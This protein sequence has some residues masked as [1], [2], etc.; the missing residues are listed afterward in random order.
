M[1]EEHVYGNAPG[2]PALMDSSPREAAA[3]ALG[4]RACRY[5]IAIRF[6]ADAPVLSLLL[7]V[8]KHGRH[9]HPVIVGMNFLGNH[10][11]SPD[12][13]I[14]LPRIAFVPGMDVAPPEGRVTEAQ[15]GMQSDR[16]PIERMLE[17]GY[18]VATFYYGDV[19]PDRRDGRALS[20]QPLF[21]ESF[22][23]G[24]IAT[25]SWGMSRALDALKTMPEIEAG[26]M[27]LVGHSRQG[28]AALWAAA[29]D[30][31]V[32]LVIANNSGKGG[33]S[34]ARRNFGETVRHLV[35][36][37]PHWFAGRY[38][39]YAGNEAALPVDQH[40]LI[41]LVAPR[42]VYVASAADDGWADPKGE[43]LGLA[44]ANPV[45]RLLGTEGLPAEEQPRVGAPIASTNGY[46]IRA[47][48]HGVT[49]YDW[50]RFLDFCDL[51]RG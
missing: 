42:P 11:V 21:P 22:G 51:H 4:G 30:P 38:A 31:R 47:G 48:G 9:P 23:W 39:G 17:R 35:T 28:K 1:F 15:R 2:A 13:G 27:A 33:A 12:P 50:E 20:V 44:G 43:F 32:W 41:S 46:H 6:D 5:Q 40:M 49:A 25:W 3:D 14:D 26:R 8:P 10:T 7:Y 18:A 29:L 16:W 19:F 37:Y 24:A 45:Y 34:L 36:R